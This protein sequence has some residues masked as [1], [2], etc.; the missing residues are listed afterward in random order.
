MWTMRWTRS[1]TSAARPIAPGA[2]EERMTALPNLF[3]CIM[4][5]LATKT[6]SIPRT[7]T[8][9]GLRNSLMRFAQDPQLKV[10]ATTPVR[11]RKPDLVDDHFYRSPSQMAFDWDHYDKALR[12]GPQIFVGEWASQ[13]GRPTPDL[14][15]ALADAA[16][17]MGLERNADLIPIECYA[18]L[19]VNV[20]AADRDKGYPRLAVGYQPDRI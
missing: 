10:I 11:S 9:A 16:W 14:N 17:L 7:V 12:D 18:P 4:L 19:L 3:R 5:K 1:N 6:G 15:A 8:M 20:N 2:S 13:E